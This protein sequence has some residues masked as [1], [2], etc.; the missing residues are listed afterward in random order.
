MALGQGGLRRGVVRTLRSGRFPHRRRSAGRPAFSLMLAV[1]TGIST[2]VV[3][4]SIGYMRG[5]PGYWRF[6]A[7][8]GLFVF[9]MSLLVSADNFCC[10][11]WDGNWWGFR[12]TC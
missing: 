12:A 11:I 9:S 10:S 1:V 4:Y 7:Y 6:F 8:M 2:L 3:V 5:D